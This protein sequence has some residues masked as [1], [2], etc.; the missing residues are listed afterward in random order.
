MV[1]ITNIFSF[2]LLKSS[3]MF[4]LCPREMGSRKILA[5]SLGSAAFQQVENLLHCFAPVAVPGMA[6]R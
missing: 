3:S 6:M 4:S 5:I 2:A 1:Q